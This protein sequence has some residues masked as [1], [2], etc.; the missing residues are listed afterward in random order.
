MQ[1]ISR[2]SG[3][4]DFLSNFY[5]HP[6]MWGGRHWITAEHAYQAAKTLD[7][8]WRNAIQGAESAGKA[9]RLGQKCPMRPDWEETKLVWMTSVLRCKFQNPS[10]MRKLRDTGGALLIEGNTWGDK[11]WGQCPVGSGHN[12]LGKI[13]MQLRDEISCT[14]SGTVL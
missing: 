6:F 4:F 10:L 13:L 12:H 1:T 9:K 5:V 14:P 8:D 2:F 3:E 11:Y 7:I